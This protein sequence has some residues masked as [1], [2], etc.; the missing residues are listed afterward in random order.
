MAYSRVQN[1]I[2][3]YQQGQQRHDVLQTTQH[4]HL[5]T[6]HDQLVIPQWEDQKGIVMES[7]PEATWRKAV[8]A[9]W[10]S[11]GQ[12]H[13]ILTFNPLPVSSSRTQS[14]YYFVMYIYIC[15]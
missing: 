15:I 12:C 6:Y 4:R 14:V 9:A 13:S 11:N 5:S 2:D 3:W 1:W 7:G 10:Q 8:H